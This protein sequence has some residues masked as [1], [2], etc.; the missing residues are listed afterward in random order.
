[1]SDNS[2]LTTHDSRPLIKVCG[3]REPGN[4]GQ[5]AELKPDYMGFIFQPVSSRYVGRDPDP[6]VFERV[7]PEIGKIG[8]FVNQDPGLLIEQCEKYGFFAA[9][10]HGTETPEYC[11]T[12][13]ESG[14]AVIKAF[15]LH[16]TFDFNIMEAYTSAAAYFLF[17]T[18]GKLAGGTGL[19]FNWEILDRYRLPVPFFLSGGIGPDDVKQ[20]KTIRHP[21]FSGIDI[22]SGFEIAPAMKDTEA[23][24]RF[25]E[26]IRG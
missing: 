9:Q 23:V 17:D 7:P 26:E 3:M 22:N 2:Q 19:K 4:I 18:K 11:R 5:I 12:V 8:V 10:L 1:M 13:R 15:S 24:R 14:L 20:L 21:Q 25:M 6:S 16:D